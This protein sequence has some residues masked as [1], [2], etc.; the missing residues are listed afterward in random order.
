MSPAGRRR[1][2]LIGART[3]RLAGV[4]RDVAAMAGAL[5]DWGFTS[6]TCAGS[7]ATRS[8]ILD[9]Y[10]RFVDETCVEDAALVYYSGHGG[11]S[12][13]PEG[14]PI[15]FIEPVDYDKS[16]EH[17]FR[18]ITSLELSLL[19]TRLTSKTKNVTVVLDSCHA[20]HM[21]RDPEKVVKARSAPVPYQHLAAHLDR[22]RR[23]DP[24]LARWTPPGNPDAVRIVACAPEQSAYEYVNADGV[25]TGLLTDVLVRTLAEAKD[26][27]LAVSWATVVDR[28]RRRV[29]ALL[30]V[31]R[32]EAE[33][34][35]RR[36]LFDVAES[37]PVAT[38]PAAMVAGR[39]RLSGAALLGV[40]PGD[41]FVVVPGESAGPDGRRIGEVRVDRV[42]PAAA[43]GDLRPAAAELPLGA[44]AHP[45]RTV[46]P[47]MPVRLAAA[48]PCL[49]PLARA[50]EAAPLIR[51]G[52]PG[53]ESPVEVGRDDDGGLVVH[54]ESGPLHRPRPAGSEGVRRII[55]DLT[56]VARARAL[57]CLSEQPGEAPDL[58]VS[59]EFGR[60][61]AG[62]AVPLSTSGSVL[63]LGQPIYVRVRNES[64][65]PIY[66]SLL[67]IGVAS[68]ISVLNPSSPSGVRLP[69]G[70]QYTFGGN[71]LTGALRGVALSWPAELP[72]TVPRP[73][74]IVVLVTAEPVDSRVLEQDGVRAAPLRTGPSSGRSL[75]V[76]TIDFELVPAPALPVDTAHFEVDERPETST[77]LWRPGTGT[78]ADVAVSLRDVAA[79]P[80]TRLDVLV[81][82]GSPDGPPVHFE[83]T[84]HVRA[85]RLAELPVHRGAVTGYLDIAVW[86]SLDSP[87]SP[88]L[89]ELLRER[90][91]ADEPGEPDV[92]EPATL[93]GARFTTNIVNAADAALRAASADCAGLYR[94][95]LLGHEEFGA[96]RPDIRTTLQAGRVSFRCLV[97]E[98]TPD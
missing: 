37:D 19:L 17:D 58:P 12:I 24:W 92:A 75:R 47:A 77:W 51:L 38:L 6:T 98:V 94:T 28:V 80:G 43:W 34:P 86:A 21:S 27:R 2:L 13:A 67:D 39:V 3:G 76:R 69:P 31:Q 97:E 8:G 65:D 90:P 95:T 16:T 15:Q 71:D 66:V 29:L 54:D 30:P 62:R 89:H 88:S 1:A 91:V 26:S 72:R 60:V 11:R 9:A 4:E 49:A 22:L 64:P 45:L 87:G 7:E 79:K 33:G 32:P 78:S 57:R 53:E 10:S 42:D 41:E 93:A 68:A 70:G 18:G 48:D 50:V 56:R 63:H 20:A 73:E 61:E 96:G 55:R 35:A 14:A 5:G 81:V 83:R 46:T 36:L 40:V 59:I 74:T 85:P 84:E 23:E 44:R 82:T 52:R 25:R